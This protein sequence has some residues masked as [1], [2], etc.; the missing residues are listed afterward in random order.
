MPSIPLQEIFTRVVFED[1]YDTEKGKTDKHTRKN[2]AVCIQDSQ[3]C[4]I[5][6]AYAP[7]AETVLCSLVHKYVAPDSFLLSSKGFSLK[8]YIFFSFEINT[9]IIF[10]HPIPSYNK[11]LKNNH[12]W[13]FL[14]FTISA[15]GFFNLS[16]F[17]SLSH[18]NSFQPPNTR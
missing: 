14:S 12:C 6:V 5:Q 2:N 1:K 18:P 3:R 10:P 7:I 13:C 16:P 4:I 11:W 9:K 8:V 15:T 17:Q